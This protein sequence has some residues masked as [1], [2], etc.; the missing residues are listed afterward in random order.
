M[1]LSTLEYTFSD[2]RVRN[3][4]KSICDPYVFNTA[5][6]RS[7]SLVVS[8]GNPFMLL[9]IEGYMQQK[10][11]SKARCWREYLKRCIECK[12]FIVPAAQR[13]GDDKLLDAERVLQS[14][15]FTD[16]ESSF[17]ILPLPQDHDSILAV[18][19]KVFND[20]PECKDTQLIISRKNRNI[21][22]SLSNKATV[23]RQGD[24]W[25]QDYFCVQYECVLC[26]SRYDKAD[27]IPLDPNNHPV[28]IL[29]ANNR[30]G[31]FD[32]DTVL[33]GVF[34]NN[35]L[36]RK[37]RVIK[38]ILH[39]SNSLKFACHVDSINPILFVPLNN[40]DPKLL[41]LPKLTRDL[42]KRK[43][44]LG[45]DKEF[46]A[47]E[48]I[49]FKDTW[50]GNGLPQISDAIPFRIAHKMLFIVHF[51]CWNPKYRLPLGIVIAAIPQGLSL[52][53]SQ[54]LLKVEHDIPDL[55]MTIL[56]PYDSIAINPALTL[57]R[58]AFTI[59]PEG[60]QNLDDA[61]SLILLE[62][63]GSSCI[64]EM[65]VH[66]ANVAKY[67]EK[68]SDEDKR[69]H[70]VGSS[71]YGTRSSG[72]AHLLHSDVRS[73][74]SLFPMKVRDV[75]SVVCTVKFEDTSEPH[76]S[77][78]VIK[79]S[80]IV[81]QLQLTYQAANNIL[82]GTISSNPSPDIES[83]DSS[84]PFQPS[85]MSCLRM[86]YKIAYGHRQKRLG[87][88]DSFNYTISEEGEESCWQA[89]LMVEE[90]MIWA[91][92]AIAKTVYSDFSNC[93]LLRRQRCPNY[94]ERA[95][96]L[97]RH[98]HILIH[99]LCLRP[100]ISQPVTAITFKVP[101]FMIERLTEAVRTNDVPLL[102]YLLTADHYYPQLAVCEAQLQ[103][104][105][106]KAEYC[107][108][109]IENDP[110]A[111]AHYSLKL[112]L[113]THFTSP[114]RRYMDIEVQRMLMC[115]LRNASNKDNCTVED[116]YGY[117]VQMCKDLCNQLNSRSH[118]AKS[119]EN[120][121]KRVSLGLGLAAH[122][123]ECSAFVK[124]LEKS[125][126]D[127]C[128]LDLV[129]KVLN[130]KQRSIKLSSLGFLEKDSSCLFRY[131]WRIKILSFDES[132]SLWGDQA[133]FTIEGGI[134]EDKSHTMCSI[135]EL[136][137]TNGNNYKA[138]HSGFNLKQSLRDVDSE[139]WNILQSEAC[140]EA[141]MVM[142]ES[143]RGSSEAAV[144]PK[145][146]QSSDLIAVTK[147][148]LENMSLEDNSPEQHHFT[149]P[150]P[151]VNYRLVSNIGLYDLL[152][153]WMSWECKDELITPSIQMLQLAPNAHICIQHNS[154]PAEY[155]SDAS[156]PQASKPQYNSILEYVTLWEPLVLAEG[157]EVSVKQ[158]QIIIIQNVILN[159]PELSIPPDSVDD[160]Y[161]EP[162]GPINV[163]IPDHF[164]E[165]SAVCI[166]TI[167]IGDMM[168]V[169]YGT[170][171][172]SKVKA[173]YHMVV[174]KIIMHKES[175]TLHSLEMKI[176]GKQNCRISKEVKPI[177]TSKC[178]L[179]LIHMATSI[180]Y[181]ALPFIKTFE[182]YVFFPCYRRV[183][184]TLS[185]LKVFQ[186]RPVSKL[187]FNIALGRNIPSKRKLY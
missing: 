183:F 139:K 102:T 150:S 181:V 187:T 41:N 93:A 66:I 88:S 67:V 174:T 122:S 123:I 184:S 40:K 60:A 15:I 177:L 53:H 65:A 116:N 124:K 159:W 172:G 80:Q 12:T 61:I 63:T 107:C 32:G 25:P 39:H 131:I 75:I 166:D 108:P 138:V 85:L 180:Q 91:N 170:L 90:L 119:F 45:F 4:T 109:S 178:E 168:C 98:S 140:K 21:S 24:D 167:R 185:K 6:T 105:N 169:R 94:E 19:T 47:T 77:E 145:E 153:V 160:F 92:H 175:N 68:H 99:S 89:H 141:A 132:I 147:A 113:Y 81:S 154:S 49:V 101:Q 112:D 14:M 1:F 70:K 11:G 46:K 20:T 23:V 74:L 56:K 96:C 7:Q 30:R 26:C 50:D 31:A 76:L 35:S 10:Y 111:I 48:V 84:E 135:E 71:A 117:T 148:F 69:A 142:N 121:L 44:Q 54:R 134:M 146:C 186:T 173:V 9:K 143:K 127:L 86:L 58:R 129:F 37:G 106:H 156:L 2:G 136:E 42:L 164:H 3:P 34:D 36:E 110:A 28:K 161:Y 97:A 162:N 155:F 114:I 118:A 52:F 51:L 100:L 73:K 78:P 82:V 158:S 8:I 5:I 62:S 83:F 144:T 165:T 128:F 133:P 38:C 126:V 152:K 120:G 17:E 33:V 182:S 22:W 149:T 104:S 29:G 43:S 179:Q 137:S 171:P 163:V 151:V 72:C 87:I 64:Y 27:A 79:E 176:F 55:E 95:A 130:P 157:A 57:N 125:S 18:Y 103:T 13:S 59:D 115:R 16:A